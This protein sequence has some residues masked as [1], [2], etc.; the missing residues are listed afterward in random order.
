MTIEDGLSVADLVPDRVPVSIGVITSSGIGKENGY[1]NTR[2]QVIRLVKRLDADESS[3]T[4]IFDQA[5]LHILMCIHQNPNLKKMQSEMAP[6]HTVVQGAS[7][8]VKSLR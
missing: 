2:G 5:V 7:I 6:Q 1:V 4:L 3:E 8:L